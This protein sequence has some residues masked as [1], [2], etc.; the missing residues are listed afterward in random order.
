[1]LTLPTATPLYLSVK[2]NSYLVE[3]V[4]TQATRWLFALVLKTTFHNLGVFVGTHEKFEPPVT[5]SSTTF[6]MERAQ[7][8]ALHGMQAR[9]SRPES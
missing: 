7:S 3:H 4:V 6:A 1:M 5:T 9:A 2:L 8:A